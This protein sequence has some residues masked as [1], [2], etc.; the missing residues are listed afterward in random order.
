MMTLEQMPLTALKGVGPS[1]SA[2]LAAL[3]LH[4]VQDLLFHL[5]LRY[6]DRTRIQPIAASRLGM[7]LQIEG[8]VVSTEL[9]FGRR[10]SLLCRIK[11]DSGMITMRLFHF[12][13]AQKNALKPGV[14]VR[15][16]GEIR[17]GK[18]GLE[19]YHPEYQFIREGDTGI[20]PTHLTP[21]YPVTEGLAQPRLRALIDQALAMLGNGAPGNGALIDWLP[22]SMR[23][24]L[25]FASLTEA[26]RFLHH[27][28]G[29]GAT[30]NILHALLEGSHPAQQRLAFEELLSHRLCLRRLR[31]QAN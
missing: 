30:G 9:V 14:R 2:R 22:E 27:P 26:V 21:V 4:N 28:P 10:R 8:E 20:N 24:R 15:C 19:F 12:S 5:P 18:T 31:Q 29:D 11:D 25:G 1:L 23:Q 16:Y 3:H 13:A 7:E 17:L 6:Q